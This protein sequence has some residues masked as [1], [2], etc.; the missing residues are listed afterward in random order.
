MYAALAVLA[1]LVIDPQL[2]GCGSA[3]LLTSG[4]ESSPYASGERPASRSIGMSDCRTS[5]SLLDAIE[6][7]VH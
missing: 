7:V 2:L 6:R 3:T 4:V 1:L 5:S